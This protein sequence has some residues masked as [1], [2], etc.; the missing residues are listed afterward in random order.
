MLPIQ[1]RHFAQSLREFASQPACLCWGFT[2]PSMQAK[3]RHMAAH[4]F[5]VY[6]SSLR[7]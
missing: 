1:A 2:G 7:K 4:F 6:R 3:L 5:G